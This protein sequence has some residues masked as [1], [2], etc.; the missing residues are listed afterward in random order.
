M[1]AFK[2]IN[3][4]KKIGIGFT[5]LVVMFIGLNVYSLS[6]MKTL[7][8][9]TEQLYK[10]PLAVSNAVRDIN[11]EIV[12]IQR[13]M[14]DI[15]LAN[16]NTQI[17]EAQEAIQRAQEKT[18][19]S[20]HI[21]EERF[22]GD[23]N[24]LEEAKQI[25]IKW[26]PIR[27]EVIASLSRGEKEKAADITRNKGA[28]YVQLMNTK[29]SYLVSFADNKAETFFQHAISVEK[30]VFLSSISL[31]VII[32]I[33]SIIFVFVISKEITTSIN[34]FKTGLLNFFKYINKERVKA[35]LINVESEDEIG[36][37]AFLV[38]E[39][40][41]K[42]ENMLEENK[43]LLEEIKNVI[44]EAKNGLFDKRITKNTTDTSLQELKN[45][46]NNMLDVI[47]TNVGSD[48]NK[49]RDVLHSFSRYDF[50]QRIYPAHA[51][52]EK[53]INEMADVIV[54][55]ISQNINDADF[56]ANNSIELTTF[57]SKL[58]QTV[59]EQ[60]RSLEVVPQAIANISASLENT[61]EQSMQMASQSEDIKSV[62]Q[63]ISEIA[64][65]TNLLALNAAIEAARAGEHGRGFAVVADEVRK[66]AEKTQK[67]LSDINVNVGTLAQSIVD[68]GDDITRQTKEIRQID[69][70]VVD[71]G[72]FNSVNLEIAVDAGSITESIQNISSKIK[73]ETSNKII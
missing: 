26:K 40:I 21:L 35:E 64:E 20:F 73:K 36:Q 50:S 70:L 42:T 31:L 14:K 34:S 17:K 2:N 27:D 58:T 12:L 39:N 24:K 45:V 47:S 71:I 7:S 46:F 56:L 62:V 37:M 49:L 69:E 1:K 6:Q 25:F 33:L 54:S 57:T 52:M 22:L 38:N 68:I 48:I 5:I 60:S 63:I 53:G 10:H 66:L 55:M 13:W 32:T 16:N 65:Q 30:S 61:S 67:S 18:L 9:L 28:K 41:A 8:S 11:Y 3:L 19:K 59:E 15:V 72:K 44:Q 43:L 23:T 51:D 29:M 4:G